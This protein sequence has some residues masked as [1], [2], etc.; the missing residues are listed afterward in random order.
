MLQ[1]HSGRPKA[2]LKT[3]QALPN[4]QGFFHGPL[5]VRVEKRFPRSDGGNKVRSSRHPLELKAPVTPRGFSF[6]NLSADLLLTIQRFAR[7]PVGG[8]LR[9]SAF[10]GSLLVY[11]KCQKSVK[12]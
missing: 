3:Y 1:A 7:F 4:W 9:A 2:L 5:S 10:L 8:C 11:L 12:F 6:V